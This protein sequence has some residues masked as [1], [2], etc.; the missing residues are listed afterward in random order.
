MA[1][2]VLSTATA[3]ST[4]ARLLRARNQITRCSGKLDAT[5]PAQ[6]RHYCEIV[7]APPAVAASINF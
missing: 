2:L 3:C 1:T 7:H 6:A 5:Q 4:I